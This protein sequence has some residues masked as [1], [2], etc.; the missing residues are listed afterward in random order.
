MDEN[1][2][3]TRFFIDV[4]DTNRKRSVAMLIGER[5]CYAHRQE[6]L[7]SLTPEDLIGQIVEHCND[8]PD[9]LLPDTPLKEAI[10]RVLLSHS[11]EPMTAEEVTQELSARWAMSAHPRDLS[12]W[13]IQR[14][15]E[16]SEQY[17]LT[18]LQEPEVEP[19]PEPEP[20]ESKAE[21]AVEEALTPAPEEVVSDPAAAQ[22]TST[23]AVEQGDEAQR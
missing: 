2:D 9:Y 10:F 21:E 6:D 18:K 22:D 20:E 3:A 14:L 19:P 16:H 5:R 11:N 7:G 15:M 17:S 13:V 4:D 8:T 23:E 12:P 1:G